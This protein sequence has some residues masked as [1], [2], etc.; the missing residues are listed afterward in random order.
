MEHIQTIC[1]HTNTG[2]QFVNL[3]LR[4]G[5]SDDVLLLRG[6]RPEQ[7]ASAALVAGIH[8]REL[9]LGHLGQV[10]LEVEEEAYEA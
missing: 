7:C 5:P 1:T 2:G 10:V 8:I 4:G 6:R 3:L 9:G